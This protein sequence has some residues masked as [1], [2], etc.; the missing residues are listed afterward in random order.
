MR[1]TFSAGN[2]VAAHIS[3]LNGG[4]GGTE[5]VSDEVREII[6]EAVNNRF[7]FE[8]MR[9]IGEANKEN[10]GGL[11]QIDPQRGRKNAAQDAQ[12]GRP[13]KQM[14]AK[15]DTDSKAKNPV[16]RPPVRKG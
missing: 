16:G 10:D 8:Q 2:P 12:V 6:S 13:V 3:F 7:Y 1:R 11:M 9:D 4:C 5:E 14:K 15:D